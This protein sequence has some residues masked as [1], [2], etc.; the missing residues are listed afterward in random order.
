MASSDPHSRQSQRCGAWPS[1]TTFRAS[2]QCYCMDFL[3]S[4]RS[5]NISVFEQALP[6]CRR[7]EIPG[8]S[9]RVPRVFQGELPVSGN[10]CAVDNDARGDVGRGDFGKLAERTMIDPLGSCAMEKTAN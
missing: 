6:S 5:S 10:F 7:L 4:R 1:W 9:I 8:A 3:P 2:A